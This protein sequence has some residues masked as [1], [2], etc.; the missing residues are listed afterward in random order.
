MWA[1]G[2]TSLLPIQRHSLLL[3]A[4]EFGS[5]CHFCQPI[6]LT[7]LFNM[8][9]CL[10]ISAKIYIDLNKSILIYINRVI[11]LYLITCLTISLVLC[12]FCILKHFRIILVYLYTVKYFRCKFRQI[13]LGIILDLLRVEIIVQGVLYNPPAAFL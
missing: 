13:Y 3:F 12:F 9:F 10:L 4:N 5:L 6:P 7:I 1:W 2:T 11:F 8:C